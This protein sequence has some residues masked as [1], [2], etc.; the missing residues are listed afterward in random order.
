[1]MKTI[2]LVQL[3]ILMS[4]AALLLSA[5]GGGAQAQDT[6][7]IGVVNYID[8]MAPAVDGFKEGMAELGYVDG[9]NIIYI[10]K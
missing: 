5:C 2:R 7:T 8:I 3:T 4:L 10:D 6:F 9:E 1:M